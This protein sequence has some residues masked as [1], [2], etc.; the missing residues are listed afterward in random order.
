MIRRFQD[1]SSG[2]LSPETWDWLDAEFADE[3]L[4]NPSSKTAAALAG[5]RTRYGWFVYAPEAPFSDVPADLADILAEAS[6]QGA[7]YV[8][9]DC[10]AVPN[11]DLPILHPEFA[12]GT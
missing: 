11:Q 10:D 1:V 12:D 5:G 4:R 6:R 8:L 9:L 7:E 3:M 2:H